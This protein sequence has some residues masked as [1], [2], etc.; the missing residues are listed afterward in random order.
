[1]RPFDWV[2]KNEMFE[3]MGADSDQV[4]LYMMMPGIG[5]DDMVPSRA[6]LP[7]NVQA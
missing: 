3:A 1:V 2:T 4:D 6:V 5:R 7:P